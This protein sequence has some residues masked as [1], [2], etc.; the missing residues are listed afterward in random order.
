MQMTDFLTIPRPSMHNNNNNKKKHHSIANWDRCNLFL[1]ILS[2]ADELI[3]LLIQRNNAEFLSDVIKSMG[4]TSIAYLIEDFTRFN[5]PRC[6]LTLVAIAN[7][8]AIESKYSIDLNK[9]NGY[10]F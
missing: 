8:K 2:T 6:G 10:A 7:T 1:W 5:S 4:K 9:L 3:M